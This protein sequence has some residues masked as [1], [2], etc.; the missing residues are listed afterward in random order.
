[1]GL[2][3]GPW[4][5]QCDRAFDGAEMHTRCIP[6]PPPTELQCDRAFDGAEMWGAAIDLDAD[7]KLQCDRAFDGAE[8]LLLDPVNGDLV[9]ASM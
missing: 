9:D 6:A 7:D 5:L 1:M 4:L 8:I 2:S 3:V